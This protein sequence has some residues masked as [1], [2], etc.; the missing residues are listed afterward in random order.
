MSDSILKDYP[1]QIEIPIAW[2]DMDAFQHVNN[3]VYLR[4]FES[5][6]MAYIERCNYKQIMDETGVGPILRDTSC[7]YRIP[8]TYPD[9]VIAATRV[10][11][12]EK[13]RFRMYHVVYSLEH[14]A[15]A[16]EGDAMIVCVD[17][18]QN[19]VADIP[20]AMRETILQLEPIAPE[21][22]E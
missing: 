11:Q 6:R 4:H 14:Q 12:V 13:D 15:V 9:T 22:K 1:V 16:A 17:Y 10:T 18:N 7:R 2:G 5:A 20:D 3:L 8:L 19:T 21:I